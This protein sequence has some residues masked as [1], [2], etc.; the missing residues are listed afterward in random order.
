MDIDI[1]SDLDDK[2]TIVWRDGTREWWKNL[3]RHR[4][5]DKPAVEYANGNRMWYRDGELKRESFVGWTAIY[6][7]EERGYTLHRS[8]DG[9]Y[10]AGCY[11]FPDAKAAIA[12][13][14]DPYYPDPERGD[15]YTAAIKTAE[16]A[17]PLL[18][19]AIWKCRNLFRPR[20]YRGFVDWGSQC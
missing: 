20:V 15:K 3:K 9:R 17:Q 18:W 7:D 13:W 6:Q 12:H 19:R 14:G 16:A 1:V 11:Q 5:G 4:D 2:P 8:R 10:R